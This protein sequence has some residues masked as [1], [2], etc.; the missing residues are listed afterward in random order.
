MFRGACKKLTCR[1][2]WLISAWELHTRDMVIRDRNHPSIVTYSV[3]NEI[4]DNLK[5]D[6]WF[7]NT[8]HLQNI[9]HQYDGK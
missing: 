7:K 8:A 9:I 3:G 5:S 1:K 2:R 4:H 6:S